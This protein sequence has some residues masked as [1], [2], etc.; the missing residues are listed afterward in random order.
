M[1]KSLILV[2]HFTPFLIHVVMKDCYPVSERI[3][4]QFSQP[5]GPKLPFLINFKHVSLL[6]KLFANL[7]VFQ[8]TD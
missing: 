5:K 2:L 7:S 3:L 8:F 1:S 4:N 6:T